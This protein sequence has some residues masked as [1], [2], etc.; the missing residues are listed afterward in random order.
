MIDFYWNM[1]GDL[2]PPMVCAILADMPVAALKVLRLDALTALCT[3]HIDNN[4]F[5]PAELMVAFLESAARRGTLDRIRRHARITLSFLTQLTSLRPGW[6]PRSSI[7]QTAPPV[8]SWSCAVRITVTS[9]GFVPL[10]RR[11]Q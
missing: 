3:E 2:K 10:E 6:S 8:S 5:L 11:H 1:D 9:I 7:R 4:G